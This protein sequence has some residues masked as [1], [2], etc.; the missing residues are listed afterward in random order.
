MPY[1][2]PTYFTIFL[3]FRYEYLSIILRPHI[4]PHTTPRPHTTSTIHI[5]AIPLYHPTQ[6]LLTNHLPIPHPKTSPQYQ[7]R[8]SPPW[9]TPIPAPIPHPHTN[10]IPR[11]HNYQIVEMH[12]THALMEATS[13]SFWSCWIKWFTKSVNTWSLQTVTRLPAD[14]VGS[15]VGFR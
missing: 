15:R 11:P 5:H 1:P 4:S 6:T 10:P 12:C 9:L 13:V 14:R 2:W 7:P 8:T 3:T